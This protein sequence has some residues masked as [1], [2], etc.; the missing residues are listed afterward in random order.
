VDGVPTL[1]GKARGY[2]RAVDKLIEIIKRDVP[3]HAERV[4]SISHT[5]CREKALAFKEELLKR[6]HVKD[7]YISESNALIATYANRGGYVVSL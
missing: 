6:L 3:S 7:V 4:V 5:K 2:N 1:L